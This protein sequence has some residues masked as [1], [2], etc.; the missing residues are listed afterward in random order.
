MI[1]CQGASAKIQ[2]LKPQWT[3][4]ISAT[5]YCL[6]ERIIEYISK[7]IQEEKDNL[8]L[9][10]DILLLAIDFYNHRSRHSHFSS[11]EIAQPLFQKPNQKAT[12]GCFQEKEFPIQSSYHQSI[13]RK[14]GTDSFPFFDSPRAA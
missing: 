6:K 5:R 1:K 2:N 7:A 8:Q 4:N 11:C 9:V 13:F 12:E 10:K 3:E 14:R